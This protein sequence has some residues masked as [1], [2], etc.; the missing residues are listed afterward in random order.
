MQHSSLNTTELYMKK[1]DR[2]T[3]DAAMKQ[4]YL[5]KNQ[6]NRKKRRIVKQIHKLGIST[7]ELM[8][9]LAGEWVL[10]INFLLST[11]IL[12]TC[13]KL[14]N[15]FTERACGENTE[16][17]GKLFILRLVRLLFFGRYNYIIEKQRY[18]N[19]TD[20]A[21]HYN[22]KTRFFYIKTRITCI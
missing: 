13:I 9:L 3:E 6:H 7:Q 2:R 16:M 17:D 15:T 18:R 19:V 4:I 21:N 20:K 14:L 8:E 12:S 11:H 22:F 10:S 5:D 1:L